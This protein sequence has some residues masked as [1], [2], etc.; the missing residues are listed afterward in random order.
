MRTWRTPSY[1]TSKDIISPKITISSPL[2]QKVYNS[3]TIHFEWAIEEE[4]FKNAL[5][6]LD[7]YQTKTPIEKSGKK[8]LIL[9]NG[10][11]SIKVYTEDDSRNWSEKNVSFSVDKII[12]IVINPFISPD[13]NGAAYNALTTKAERDAFIQAKLN[14]DCK[15]RHLEIDVVIILID[16]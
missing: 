16:I 5:Y 2:E 8:D 10:D 6:S 7:N 15:Y 12:P 4:N 9:N 14:E 11:W 1:R 3:D 13:A